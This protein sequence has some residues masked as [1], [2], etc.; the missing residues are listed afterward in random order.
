MTLNLEFILSYPI[1]H[2]YAS[3]VLA[4]SLD[5]QILLYPCQNGP[6][7][8]GKKI[9]IHWTG[10]SLSC[11]LGLQISPK[12]VQGFTLLASAVVAPAAAFDSVKD[13]FVGLSVVGAA[14]PLP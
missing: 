7:N 13:T 5:L 10:C 6:N 4:A 2:P 9:T 14:A 12:H 3:Q 8:S 11:L 1:L